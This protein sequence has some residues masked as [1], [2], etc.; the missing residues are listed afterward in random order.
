[1]L[2][3]DDPRPNMEAMLE[4]S[5]VDGVNQ[6]HSGSVF[7]QERQA[8]VT[9]KGQ[10]VSMSRFV[11]VLDTFSVFG[12]HGKTVSRRSEWC[13]GNVVFHFSVGDWR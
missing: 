3:H 9:G 8:M 1:M 2:R 10:E 13:H 12:F 11:V 6:P 4:T 5:T 7:G